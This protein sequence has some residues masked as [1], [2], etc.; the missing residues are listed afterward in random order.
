[1][2]GCV[3]KMVVVVVV[4]VMVIV[5]AVLMLVVVY[6]AFSIHQLVQSSQEL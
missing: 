4:M 3:M 6:K 5:M 1:M 2:K